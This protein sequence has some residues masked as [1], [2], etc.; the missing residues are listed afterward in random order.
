MSIEHIKQQL[1]EL[2]KKIEFLGNSM[3][4]DILV[5]KIER[6]LGAITG[7][8]ITY[9][10]STRHLNIKAWWY[11]FDKL[12]NHT[13]DASLYTYNQNKLQALY[14]ELIRVTKD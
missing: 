6:E 1:F 5:A 8:T 11:H 3:D 13:T 10:D 12:P 14:A 2:A 7:F 9:A 4:E